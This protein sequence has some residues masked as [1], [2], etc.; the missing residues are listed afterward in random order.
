M[1]DQ[2]LA[3]LRVLIT[4]SRAQSAA[5]ETPLA[6][7]IITLELKRI[8][9][10]HALEKKLAEVR[11]LIPLYKARGRAYEHVFVDQIIN[12]DLHLIAA[13]SNQHLPHPPSP[14]LSAP[15]MPTP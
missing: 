2:R 8:E 3:Q 9:A 11:V 15:Q 12:L 4:Q 5:A 13:K 1:I 10:I 6:N 14:Q 7:E